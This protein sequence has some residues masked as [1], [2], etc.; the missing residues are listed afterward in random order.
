[1]TL[2]MLALA[3]G[4]VRDHTPGGVAS[5]RAGRHEHRSTAARFSFFPARAPVPAPGCHRRATSPHP[6]RDA[7]TPRPTAEATGSRHPP[8]P[9]AWCV[10]F[11]AHPR[12]NL[13]LAV[14]REVVAYF[15]TST[16]ATSRVPPDP[17]RSG[18]WGLPLAQ[19]CRS[20]CRRASAAPAGSRG[21]GPERTPGSRRHLR[22]KLSIAAAVRTGRFL[23]QNRPFLT[24]QMTRQRPSRRLPARSRRCR[25]P[26]V[27]EAAGGS[28]DA[29]ASSSSCNS[30]C[31]ICR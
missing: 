12:I 27:G 31:S 25:R 23:G 19:S 2:R 10:Q 13:F 14:Q 16:C 24:R 5:P 20:A 28:A 18:G 8:S 7:V 26:G 3:I 29:V 17:G 1:M 15:D 11:H 21:S 6:S 9:P 4:R 22:R 30:N